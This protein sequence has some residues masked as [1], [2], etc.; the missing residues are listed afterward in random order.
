[1]LLVGT[2]PYIILIFVPVNDIKLKH[3]T[4]KYTNLEELQ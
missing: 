4:W 2:I 3:L 1:M